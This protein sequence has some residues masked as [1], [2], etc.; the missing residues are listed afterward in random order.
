MKLNYQQ[1]YSDL[2]TGQMSFDQFMGVVNAAQA[3]GHN[4][5]GRL[6]ETSQANAA[7]PPRLA[8]EAVF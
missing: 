8:Y 1:I 2:R 5:D 7:Q 4:N 3:L 6:T